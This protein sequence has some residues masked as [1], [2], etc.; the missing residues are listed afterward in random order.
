MVVNAPFYDDPYG[1]L[2][3]Y[4]G[5]FSIPE[6]ASL[7]DIYI[8]IYLCVM[9]QWTVVVFSIDECFATGCS[10]LVETI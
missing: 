9:G 6:C 3:M 4:G 7:E 8:Y 2:Y 1:I 10:P 5:V